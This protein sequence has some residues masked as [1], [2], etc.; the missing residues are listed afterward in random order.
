MRLYTIL[1]SIATKLTQ[2]DDVQSN[3]IIVDSKNQTQNTSQYM[4]KTYEL[5][6]RLIPG[7]T[8]TWSMKAN[9]SSEKKA[10][11]IWVGGGTYIAGD[12][13]QKTSNGVYQCT[14]VANTNHAVYNTIN[15]YC[16]NNTGTQGS[17]AVTGTCTI[18]WIKIEKGDTATPWCA[19][20]IDLYHCIYPV[21]Y[22]Y[23]SFDSMSPSAKFGGTWTQITGRFIRFA[24]DTGTG[25]SDTH[26]L[27]L[28]QIP[29][30]SHTYERP[31]WTPTSGSAGNGFAYTSWYNTQTNASGS[32]N[33]HN[34]M[35]VYQ[36]L[37]VWRRTA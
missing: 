6:E 26:T 7:L 30:H 11:G 3:N 19:S 35:P 31:N 25:G 33:S 14:F 2:N 9:L 36:N 32:G 4:V 15:V 21:G 20:K 10:I 18:E 29:S 23:M 34:N 8:Y 5:E 27:S 37:Y 12:I 1:N 24:S 28:A 16:S 22:V 13:Q 17:T